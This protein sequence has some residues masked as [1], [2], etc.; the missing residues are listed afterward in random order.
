M[1]SDEEKQIDSK[2]ALSPVVSISAAQIGDA[3]QIITT[4]ISPGGKPVE[5][6]GD[7][8]EAMRLAMAAEDVELTPEE[9]S[10]LLAKID[11]YILPL[12]CFLYAVQ[13]MDKVTNGNAA[14]MGLKTDL[15][16][17]NDMY[18]WVG[19]A[20]YLGYLAFEFPVSTLLQRFPLAKTTS[21][22]IFIWGVVLC[23]HATPNYAG[24][25]FLRTMLG[26][27]ESSVTPAMVIITS[28]WY[29]KEEQFYRTCIWFACNGF[30]NI[31]G[32]AIAY[33]IALHAGKY[34]VEGWKILFIVT[35]LITC[36]VAVMFWFHIP[37]SPASAWFLTEKE[38]LQVVERIRSNNQGFGNKHFKKKQLIEALIDIRTWVF[39]FFALLT[40]IPNGG[41][42][43]F[44]SIL[45]KDDFGYSTLDALLM[46][47]VGGAVELVGCPLFGWLNRFIPHRMILAISSIVL[48]FIGACM[49]AFANESKQARLAGYY[50]QFIAPVG[51]IACLS[52][53][54]SNV[55]G[56]TKKITVNAIYLI[57]YCV[58]NLIGPQTF[59]AEDAPSYSPAKATIVACYAASILV[60][61]WIYF[62]YWNDNRKRDR[63]AA[64]REKT[65][66]VGE[67][68]EME[69]MEFADLTDKENPHFRYAL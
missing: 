45:M 13:F 2:D 3:H 50:L 5:V 17:I 28:Q 54:S 27:F 7:V 39:F 30:G 56:H 57:G 60:L 6:T 23:L 26:A 63:I 51:M 18:T 11:L 25:I 47:M 29:R 35:G 58:G 62:S 22:F 8:D 40:N 61:F 9:S 32:S 42:T 15:N 41:I 36:A 52:L 65:G 33:G 46:G 20:F 37:D 44:G 21:I 59:R 10:K 53:F 66:F 49:L 38:K 1:S 55:A 24:F 48:T 67:T 16:M 34:S 31:F 69:N 64:E 43:N 4:V 68:M 19:S 14:I 12:I